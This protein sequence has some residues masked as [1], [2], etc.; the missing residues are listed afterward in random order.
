METKVPALYRTI[1]ILNYIAQKG[2][3]TAS[4]IIDTLALPKSSVYLLLDE[5]KNYKFI[6][7]DENGY[8]I[9]WI[10]LVELGELASNQ[11]DI[12]EIARKHLAKLTNETGMLSH[13]GILENETAYYILKFESYST[14]SVRSYVGKQVSLYRSSVGKCLLA[15]QPQE[16]IDAII[17]KINFERKTA[18][19][20]MD[21]TSLLNELNKIRSQG[22]AFDDEEDYINVRCV[23]APIFDSNNKITAAISAVGTTFQVTDESLPEI[24]NTVKKCALDISKELGY[25]LAL[26]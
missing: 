7:Q 18:T 19:T 14:I 5:L 23:A 6:K 24:V 3:C 25:S 4:E 12:R 20:L 21:K 26:R 22:W 13:L 9:L 10:K 16:K 1:N 15:L 17:E 8:Y 11:I 2:K